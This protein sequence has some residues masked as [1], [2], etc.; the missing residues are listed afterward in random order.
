MRSTDL[1]GRIGGD[2]IAMFYAGIVDRQTGEALAARVESA[3]RRPISTTGGEIRVGVSIGAVIAR[4]A[5]DLPGRSVLTHWAD[6]AM[7]AQKRAQQAGTTQ[8]PVRFHRFGLAPNAGP[9]SADDSARARWSIG[10]VDRLEVAAVVVAS[11]VV[12]MTAAAWVVRLAT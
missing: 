4:P 3:I 2:E 7:Q 10:R 6:R 11:L 12:A 5:A 8:K 9:V 1:I